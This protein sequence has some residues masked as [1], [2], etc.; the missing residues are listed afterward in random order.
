MRSAA[1]EE[2]LAPAWKVGCAVV[3]LTIVAVA[4]WFVTTIF[5][6]GHDYSVNS[7]LQLLWLDPK[8]APLGVV[9]PANNRW[10]RNAFVADESHEDGKKIAVLI[11]D[12][13]YRSG[14][15]TLRSE[16]G[17]IGDPISRKVLC[18][19]PPQAVRKQVAIDETVQRFVDGQCRPR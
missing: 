3:S 4:A 18:S 8:G 10:M 1:H 13:H 2:H 12:D 19:V 11:L 16:S 5:N 7:R 6:V 15:P 14:D 17:V 9:V